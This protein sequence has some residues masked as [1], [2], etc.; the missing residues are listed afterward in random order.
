[1]AAYLVVDTDIHDAEA[2]DRY[3]AA[4]RPI[5]ER[6]GGEYIARGGALDVVE[7]GTWTPT[8]LV[9]VKFPDAASARAAL[10]DPDYAPL[11][12]LR[13]SAAKATIAIVEGI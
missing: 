12:V 4:A 13:Q 7:D 11:R 8:R 3:K 1:M 5:L 9:I 2:Y 6:H 10:E